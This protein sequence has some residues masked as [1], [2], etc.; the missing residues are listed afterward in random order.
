MQDKVMILSDSGYWHMPTKLL[1]TVKVVGFNDSIKCY[2]FHRQYYIDHPDAMKA[3][4][5]ICLSMAS[6]NE[7]TYYKCN[8]LSHWLRRGSKEEYITHKEG[9]NM[10]NAWI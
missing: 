2:Q 1:F 3:T 4:I 5:L 8:I 6:P 7:K 10:H 9:I